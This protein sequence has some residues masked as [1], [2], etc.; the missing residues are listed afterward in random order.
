MISKLDANRHINNTERRIQLRFASHQ[1]A[2]L[3]PMIASSGHRDPAPGDVSPG[4]VGY[5]CRF[6]ARGAHGMPAG[7]AKRVRSCCGCGADASSFTFT[8]VEL[9]DKT[10]VP[11][12]S[13]D[14]MRVEETR[15]GVR[16]WR[17]LTVGVL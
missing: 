5:W 12:V 13:C 16:D 10:V 8:H 3:D 1:F 11:I 7:D 2:F 17:P 14:F 9:I 4:V 6:R 15:L